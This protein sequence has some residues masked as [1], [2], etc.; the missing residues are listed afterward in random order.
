VQEAR[1]VLI[2]TTYDAR[3][4]TTVPELQ[5]AIAR[6]EVRYAFLNT[7]CGK[8]ISPINAACSRPARWI[9]AHGTDVSREAGLSR[10]GVLWLL[11]GATQ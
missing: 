9:R 11:P 8:H 4:F 3:V 2:L 5:R 7:F 6:G 10:G 1:P